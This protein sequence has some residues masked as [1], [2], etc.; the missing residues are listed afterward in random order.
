MV[1]GMAIVAVLGFVAASLLGALVLELLSAPPRRRPITREERQRLERQGALVR[2]RL[3][4][5]R[6][7]CG[8]MPLEQGTAD[9]A[10]AA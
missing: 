9:I 7:Y 6:V 3:A 10:H 5:R 1:V 2:Q 4:S 8:G